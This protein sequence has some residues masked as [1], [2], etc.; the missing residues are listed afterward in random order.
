MVSKIETKRSTFAKGTALESLETPELPANI[1]TKQTN[2]NAPV[3]QEVEYGWSSANFG[4]V[5][6]LPGGSLPGEKGVRS[7]VDLNLAL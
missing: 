2:P 1:V 4:D 5:E 6:F 3:K 7:P